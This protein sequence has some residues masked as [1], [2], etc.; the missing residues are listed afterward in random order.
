MKNRLRMTNQRQIILQELEQYPG[1]PAADELHAR[2]KKRLPRISL[3]T[4]YRNLEILAAAGVIR[5]I[6][7][8]GRQKRFDWDR[9]QHHHIYCV[10]CHR[11][12]NI[13]LAPEGPL[14]S[15]A[16]ERGY[17]VTGF[18]I[19]FAGYCPDCQKQDDIKGGGTDMGCAQCKP[20]PLNDSQRQVLEALARS[21][22]ASG[23]KE[24]AVASG[25]DAKE[26]GSL[27]TAL[28]KKGYVESPVRC[29]YAITEEGKKAIA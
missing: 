24:I 10:R 13:T 3:T 2:I 26:V 22:N 6:E 23:N 4:V 11:V 9:H 28:K 12:D 27:I 29:K 21:G 17:A 5:K 14:L 20:S 19:E 8:S 16:D 18:R 7:I 1:H 25:L 15:T